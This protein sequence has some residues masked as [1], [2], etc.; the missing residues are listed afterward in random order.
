MAAVIKAKFFESN[1]LAEVRYRKNNENGSKNKFIER[2]YHF[3]KWFGKK[4][5]IVCNTQ[6]YNFGR[7]SET[8]NLY[9]NCSSG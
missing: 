2:A 6:E 7:E 5:Q 3:E 4:E 8:S 9:E 1:N